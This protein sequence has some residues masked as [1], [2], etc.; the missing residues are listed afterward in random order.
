MVVSLGFPLVSLGSPA[1]AGPGPRGSQFGAVSASHGTLFHEFLEA[2][3]FIENCASWLLRGASP[4]LP[5]RPGYNIYCAWLAGLAAWLPFPFPLAPPRRF[6]EPPPNPRPHGEAN[7]VPFRPPTGHFSTSFWKH[8]VL[9]KIAPPG[10]SA[11]LS[12]ASPDPKG[13]QREGKG[14]GKGREREAKGEP[15]GREREGKGKPKGSQRGAKGK[16]K[17]AKGEP[18][19]N[20]IRNMLP[21]SPVSL[22]IEIE[23]ALGNPPRP[24]TQQTK[25]NS[26]RAVEPW[27]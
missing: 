14:K 21:N 23:I 22:Q 7:L 13:S 5:R 12:R 19:T 8:R 6:P 20:H 18:N 3:G 16:P 17:G 10:S 15:K 24:Q 1:S 9:L 11:V 26:T 4:S 2:P 25:Q 27:G